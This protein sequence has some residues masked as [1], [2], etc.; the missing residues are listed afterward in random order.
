VFRSGNTNSPH[1]G[2]ASKQLPLLGDCGLASLF[3]EFLREPLS[4]T[5]EVASEQ[6]AIASSN[7]QQ[8][9]NQDASIGRHTPHG[10]GQVATGWGDRALGARLGFNESQFVTSR[11]RSCC[12]QSAEKRD[13]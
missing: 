13:F 12:E 3:F 8:V 2:A 5:E 6:A 9:R 1:H 11:S 10:V 7:W 4:Q